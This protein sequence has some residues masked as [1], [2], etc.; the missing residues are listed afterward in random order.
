MA[1][2]DCYDKAGFDWSQRMAI[3]T[4]FKS[5]ARTF[6]LVPQFTARPV[7]GFRHVET[8]VHSAN[9]SSAVAREIGARDR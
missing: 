9:H 6:L 5:G 3:F 8:Q 4:C 1:V 2:L 7:G